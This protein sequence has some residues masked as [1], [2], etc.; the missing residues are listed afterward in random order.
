MTAAL[1]LADFGNGYLLCLKEHESESKK[2]P[3]GAKV[4]VS[5]PTLS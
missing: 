1:T 2:E 3:G 4:T 5:I